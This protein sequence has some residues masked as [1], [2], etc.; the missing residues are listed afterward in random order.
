MQSQK[1][2]FLRALAVKAQR[3]TARLASQLV[4]VEPTDREEV[5][6]AF[7]F[8]RWLAG[9]CRAALRGPD[10][11]RSREHAR[12]ADGPTHSLR[13]L[14]GHP[15]RPQDQAGQGRDRRAPPQSDL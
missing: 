13:D 4:R 10:P 14:G 1:E 15:I 2:L 7:E 12:A 3:R 8:E 11:C 5:I 9:I 6:A